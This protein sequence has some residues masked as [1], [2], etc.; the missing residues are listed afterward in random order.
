MLGNMDSYERKKTKEITIVVFEMANVAYKSKTKGI[1]VLKL[2]ELEEWTWA[3]RKNTAKK[4]MAKRLNR[5]LA[6]KAEKGTAQ[7]LEHVVKEEET[8]KSL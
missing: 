6:N 2:E 5:V 1:L 8:Y 4:W 7:L 3:K